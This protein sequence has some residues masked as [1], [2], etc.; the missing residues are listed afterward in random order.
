MIDEQ[1]A[2]PPPSHPIITFSRLTTVAPAD[3]IALLNDPHVR[4]HLPLA[5]SAFGPHECERFVAEKEAHWAEHGFGVWAFY[6]DGDFAGWGGLQTEGGDLDLGLVLHRRYWGLGQRLYARF[7]VE[8]FDTLGAPSITILLPL[9][10]QHVSAVTR[11]GFKSDGEVSVG[12]ERFRRFR[13]HA[14][15]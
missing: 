14:P 10:R 3:L 15:N 2:C 9:S 5:H 13:L 7:I 12:G 4:R 11:A 6:A 1:V 8:A